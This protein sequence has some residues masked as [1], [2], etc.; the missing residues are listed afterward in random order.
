MKRLRLIACAA[1]VVALCVTSC[2]SSDSGRGSVVSPP[3]SGNQAPTIAGLSATTIDANASKTLTIR[4]TDAESPA[5]DIDLAVA[6]ADPALLPPER[7]ELSGTGTHRSVTLTPSSDASGSTAVTVTAT[8]PEGATSSSVI[9][10]SVV[11][12]P[13]STRSLTADVFSKAEDSEPMELTGKGFIPDSADDP[14]AFDALI[15]QITP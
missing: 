14:T 8:D 10:V 3:Q 4:V 1:V 5:A 13:T 11:S 7:I 15:N 2:S 12:E 6:A 9:D